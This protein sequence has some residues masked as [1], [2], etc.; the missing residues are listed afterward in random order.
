[1]CKLRFVLAFVCLGALFITG[2]L[3]CHE[4]LCHARIS[5]HTGQFMSACTVKTCMR[6]RP[7][8]WPQKHPERS[9]PSRLRK[10]R[11][12]PASQRGVTGRKSEMRCGQ[13]PA[14]GSRW[15]LRRNSSGTIIPSALQSS[16]PGPLALVSPSQGSPHAPRAR[17]V[18]ATLY[19]SVRMW[20]CGDMNRRGGGRGVWP[21]CPKAS[22][23]RWGVLVPHDFR[24]ALLLY[25][26]PRAE[27]RTPRAGGPLPVHALP[28]P[29]MLPTPPQMRMIRG[30]C[31]PYAEERKTVGGSFPPP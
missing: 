4:R 13:Q 8:A 5:A 25:A 17:G 31:V 3:A 23:I 30:S 11:R 26:R 29:E 12:G 19:A 6:A 15:S 2:K 28:A 20:V 1:M 21:I 22:C 18:T 7:M 10:E 14:G 27:D 9:L 24:A 16:T